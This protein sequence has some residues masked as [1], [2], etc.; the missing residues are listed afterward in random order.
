M[1]KTFFLFISFGFISNFTF[2][3]QIE[4]LDSSH[5]VSIRGLS[6]VDNKT[7]WISGS[8][9]TIAI[10]TDGGST[11]NWKTVKGFE[12]TD[13]RD[14]EAF[15]KKTA[16]IMGIT[17]PAVIL[18]TT[19]AGET[20]KTVY[21]NSDS[22]IFLDAMEFWND[23]SGIVIGDPVD[24]RFF[25][26]R[27]FDGGKTWQNIPEQNKPVA[28]SGEACF[29]ASGTNISKYDRDEAVFVTGGM[30]SRF[31]K[32]DQKIKLPISQGKSTAGAN[33]VDVN[34]KTVIVVGG[35]FNDPKNSDGNCA[36]SNDGG[37]T[38]SK[39]KASPH[40]YKSCV[41]FIHK[42]TW[43]ACGL[44]GVDISNDDGQTWKQIS[45]QSFHVVQKSKKGK[46]VYLA[47][48]NGKIGK[49]LGDY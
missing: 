13:F 38:W 21:E 33:S 42:K 40:G 25:I 29:A 2:S 31:F 5:T 36:V 41:T 15:D 34:K 46:T 10:T 47:G 49:L 32:R 26:G 37:N 8:T 9:G 48:A 20:W 11:W 19:D 18:R 24:H 1:I 14:I 7:A 4:I 44:T 3:Q 45:D 16:V 6:V 35:D 22:S 28:D 39:P 30:T 43:I 17:L 27:S 23:M 12:N